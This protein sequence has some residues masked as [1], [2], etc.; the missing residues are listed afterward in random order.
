L[1]RSTNTPSKRASSASLPGSISK[2]GWFF[3]ASQVA[4]VSGVADERLVALFKLAR[5]AG[6]DRLTVGAVFLGLRLVAAHDVA[7]S[8]YLDLFDEQLRLAGLALDEERHERVVIVEHDLT[9]D[10]V[11]A[12]ARAENVFELAPPNP[13]MVA[14]EIMP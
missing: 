12:L 7:A 4:A 9:R 8:L 5:K 11:G 2:A 14:C 3:V 1:V 6:E 13:A 10:G